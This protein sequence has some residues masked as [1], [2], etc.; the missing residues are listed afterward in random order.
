MP[1]ITRQQQLFSQGAAHNPIQ[2][3]ATIGIV[4]DTNDPQQMGRVRVVCSQWGDTM[5]AA[6]A[7]LP[8]A[9]YMSPFGGQTQV[10]TRGP[11]IQPSEGGIAYG[12]WWIPKVGAQV[13]VMC[14]DGNPMNRIYI[15][16][17]YDQ[18]TPHTM[19][20]GRYMYDDHPALEKSGSDAAPYG[21]YTSMEHFIHPLNE[22]QKTAFGNKAEPNY[23]Y[24]NRGADYTVSSVGVDALGRTYTS[25]QDDNNAQH[26]GWNSTQGY[27]GSRSDP[28]VETQFT[29]KN[30]DSHV[31]SL[32]TPGFH[33]FSMD[34]RQ[35]N[36]RV[37]F[38]TTS[39]HQI[40][41]DD[42]NERIYI[43]TAQGNN[44]IELDQ[45]GTI[46]MYSSNKVNIHSMR[47]L[48]LTSDETIRMTAKKGIHMMSD[49]V[50]KISAATDIHIKAAQSIKETAG[51]T[52]DI[53]AGSNLH[54][55]ADS[56]VDIKA[57]NNLN[58]ESGA[59]VS[60]RATSS[61]RA[62]AGTIHFNSMSAPASSADSAAAA[63]QAFVV[64]RIPQHEPWGRTS[65]ASDTT[66]DPEFQYTDPRINREERG[67]Q[68]ER[69][70]FWRR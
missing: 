47:D 31:Y 2:S 8:W 18:F 6:V 36:C 69:S 3:N 57:G 63:D 55:T 9:I 46:D 45:N 49:D 61:Y 50:V 60:V 26:D 10:S 33:A 24:R 58:I 65:T 43:A 27:Q 16:C 22:N 62:T 28:N 35:E 54:L 20:H 30:Y 4:V 38:R 42:T 32:V 34:D 5:Q 56:Q 21:P 1:T 40:I 11:G 53:K 70:M 64:S 29:D 41:M 37:R 48:N 39:G 14:V 23:E 7:D 15:G 67:I 25:V 19:P 52:I 66:M 51:T 68:Y 13:V 44:W 17:V 59:I 12:A